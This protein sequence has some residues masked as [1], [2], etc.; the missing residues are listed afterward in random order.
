MTDLK[1]PEP[2]YRYTPEEQKKN[3]E[4]FVADGWARIGKPTCLCGCWMPMEWDDLEGG[5]FYLPGHEPKLQRAKPINSV[6][7]PKRE[8][9]WGERLEDVIP[10][11]IV[12]LLLFLFWPN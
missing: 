6:A 3:W 1:I 4:K 9:V 11:L 10:I 2:V 12:L 7:V 5:T 8:R